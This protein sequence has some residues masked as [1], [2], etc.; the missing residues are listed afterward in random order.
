MRNT[1]LMAFPAYL[2]PAEAFD[3][4]IG[5]FHTSIHDQCNPH[6][7]TAQDFLMLRLLSVAYHV[8]D[9]LG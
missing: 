5:L 9:G 3:K 2:I 7:K 1:F 4:S 6:S 8:L